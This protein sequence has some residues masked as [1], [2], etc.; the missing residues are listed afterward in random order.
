MLITQQRD[1]YREAIHHLCLP[2]IYPEGPRFETYPALLFQRA[3]AL[4]GLLDAYAAGYSVSGRIL[5]SETFAI[6]RAKHRDVPG[7]WSYIPEI[8]ELPPDADDLGIVLQVLCRVGGPALAATCDEAIQLT[9]AA[10][11]PDGGIPTWILDPHGHSIVDETMRAYVEV[12]GGRGVHADVVSNLLYGII[13]YDTSRYR[14]ELLRTVAYL[15]AA[16]DERGVWLSKWYAGPYYGTYR[17]VSAISVLSPSSEALGRARAFLLRSQREDGSW[18][19]GWSDPLAT[20]LSVLALTALGMQLEDEAIERGITYLV[21]TQEPDGG[22]PASPFIA[23]PTLDRVVM[24]ASRRMTT[25]E[26]DGGWPA[27]PFI[28]FPTADGVVIHASRTMTTTFCLKALLGTASLGGMTPN[29]AGTLSWAAWSKEPI[30][31][32][33]S[34]AGWS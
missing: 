7:G 25:T 29:G 4:D 1:G 33:T 6:L 11:E 28:A 21:G 8:P 34:G 31:A 13:L 17:V 22:W 2:R 3:I 32:R 16:Q 30:W 24:H 12:I 14:T 20:A 18:G 27:S 15:E 9:L 26:R 19:E 5:E 10:A 23:F